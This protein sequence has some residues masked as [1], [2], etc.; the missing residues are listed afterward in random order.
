VILTIEGQQ[1]KPQVLLTQ[2]KDAVL[3]CLVIASRKQR[4]AAQFTMLPSLEN[5]LQRTANASDKRC[6]N[7]ESPV[8]NWQKNVKL[9]GEDNFDKN[10]L[11]HTGC[12]DEKYPK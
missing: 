10:I 1:I 6:V 12:P 11:R 8:K 2:A 9:T 7:S 5:S 4:R 3:R